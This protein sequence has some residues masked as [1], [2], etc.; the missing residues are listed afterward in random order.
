MASS[1]RIIGADEVVDVRVFKL[2]NLHQD[3]GVTGHGTPQPVKTLPSGP[4]PGYRQGY[5]RGLQE[6]EQRGREAARLAFEQAQ[7]ARMQ[8]LVDDFTRGAEAIQASM[9]EALA[10]L[11]EGL[12]E[13][14]IELAVALAAQ[15]LRVQL[16]E[17]P[18]GTEPVIREAIDALIDARA[19]FTLLLNPLDAER[20]GATLEPL[21]TARGARCVE[22][23]SVRAG[24]CRVLAAD[25]EVDATVQERW[26][27]ALAAIGHAPVPLDEPDA[28]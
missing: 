23:P 8:A 26:R 16:R 14:T 21:L 25:A 22:D 9:V 2:D 5:Q 7:A 20:F 11:R 17:A 13:Q 15:V 10:G 1:N 28:A 3:A 18:Q 27:R 4:P 12:A 24:G 19:S 6:G